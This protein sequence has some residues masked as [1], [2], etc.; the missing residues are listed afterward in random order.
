MFAVDAVQLP[1][2]F[3]LRCICHVINIAVKKF[4]DLITDD[5]AV[6]RCLVNSIRAS[7]VGRQKFDAIA[8][9]QNLVMKSAY[10][11]AIKDNPNAN[12]IPTP[13]FIRLP[14]TTCVTWWN[15][16]YTMLESLLQAC[17]VI[18]E[19]CSQGT[20]SPWELH[21]ISPEKWSL[22]SRYHRFL[23]DAYEC[24]MAASG[25]SYVTVSLQPKIV[26]KLLESCNKLLDVSL[27]SGTSWAASE[28]IQEAIQ[29][30]KTALLKYR[31]H[32]QGTLPMLALFL[33]PRQKRTIPMVAEMKDCVKM[34][35][36]TQYEQ[37]PSNAMTTPS[38]F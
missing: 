3:H 13:E 15:S 12:V 19:M 32:L 21:T 11:R 29:Q 31:P 4:L 9:Q 24:T 17:V 8:D 36:R 27:E 34:I 1:N 6:A 26:E 10:A 22:Y 25:E 37:T 35:I 33:D 18:D 20:R 7:M 2:D 23:K 16:T 30:M 38:S 5:I 28:R 14:T